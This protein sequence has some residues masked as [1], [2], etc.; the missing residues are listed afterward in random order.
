MSKI[1]NLTR[2]P[3]TK[4]QKKQGLFDPKNKKA[5]LR[6][7]AFDAPPEYEKILDVAQTLVAI[8]INEGAKEAAISGPA[9]LTSALESALIANGITP[10]YPYYKIVDMTRIDSSGKTVKGA[11]L[12]HISFVPSVAAQQLRK[13]QELDAAWDKV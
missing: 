12:Q 9:Y 3:I 8:A 5:V 10:I 6:L 2:M 7:L 11:E 4:E 1:I 13:R